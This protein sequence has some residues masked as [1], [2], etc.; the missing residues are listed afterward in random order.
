VYSQ[1]EVA[2]VLD[3]AELWRRGGHA[4]YDGHHASA[5]THGQGREALLY[6]LL[7]HNNSDTSCDWKKNHD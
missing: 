5:H 7:Q 4:L 6:T 2:D 1:Q 3:Q